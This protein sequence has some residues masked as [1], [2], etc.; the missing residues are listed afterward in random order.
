[1]EVV[2][3]EWPNKSATVMTTNGQVVWTFS[4]IDEARI[5]CRDWQSISSAEAIYYSEETCDNRI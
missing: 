3:M 5:A 2:I 1:M 4:N